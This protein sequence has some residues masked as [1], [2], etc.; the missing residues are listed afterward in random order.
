M[1][2]DTLPH[3]AQHDRLGRYVV[4]R[5]LGEGGMGSVYEAYDAELDRKVAVKVV[6]AD[7]ASEAHRHEN[8]QRL[9]RE[10]QAMARITHPN[11][12]AIHDVGTVGDSVFLAM[13]LVDGTTLRRWLKAKKRS[14][15]A[16][17][18]A[19]RQ[20]GAGLA[21]AHAAGLV[22]RDFK[23]DNVLV[24]RDGRVFVTDF[25]LARL[26]GALPP[27]PGGEPADDSGSSLASP[28]TV[29]G[30]VM[31]TP[32]YMS[33]EQHLGRATDARTDQFSFC[34]ALYEA[35]WN[36][37]PF[38]PRALAAAARRAEASGTQ[39]VSMGPGA[40]PERAGGRMV[41]REPPRKPRVPAR[42][43]RAVQR[44]LSLNPEERFPSLEALLKALAPPSRT[45]VWA[46]IGAGAVLA[47]VVVVV[48]AFESGARSR[49]EACTGARTAMAAVWNSSERARF[50]AAF[51]RTGAPEASTHFRRMASVLDS[52]TKSWVKTSHASCVETRVRGSQME[53]AYA[54]RRRCL[55]RELDAFRAFAGLLAKPNADL[56]TRAE[57]AAEELPGTGEC[58]DAASLLRRAPLPKDPKRA[59]AV[60]TADA[61]MARADASRIAGRYTEALGLA[62]R[63]M[64]D[65]KQTAHAPTEAEALYRVG[66]VS[67]ALGHVHEG[68]RALLDGLA[69]AD[70]GRADLLRA[71]IAIAL[72]HWSNQQGLFSQG[73]RWGT[74]ASAILR[75]IGG[76]R[77]LEASLANN[78]GTIYMDEGKRRQEIA[79]FEKAIAL[80]S[81]DLGPDDARVA[82]IEANLGLALVH[83]GKAERAREVSQSAVRNLVHLRGANSPSLVAAYTALTELDFNQAHYGPA[84]A[85][86]TKALAIAR[87]AYGN[88]SIKVA[89]AYDLLATVL[90]KKGRYTEARGNYER[91]LA[92]KQKLFKPGAA[93]LGYS[94]GDIGQCW[95][96]E[97]KPEKAVPLLKKALAI[98]FR[99]D[100][101]RGSD[102]FALATSLWALG[103]K[104][105]APRVAKQ[106]EASFRAAKV[107][108]RADEVTS[109]LR[110]KRPSAR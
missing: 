29:T 108:K 37:R 48:L 15:D 57:R 20:A 87:A 92:I 79:N 23:P 89:T 76:N 104:R 40:D 67:T 85:E 24:S 60:R 35:L 41:V 21:A 88:G 96:A 56:V 63:A 32:R 6:R 105:E 78:L 73:E 33:P 39:T 50:E 106:A 26:A 2:S 16:V 44:G 100:E 72:I 91:A 81:A 107:P 25:G 10:A 43:R 103:R 30:T 97:G 65:A 17:L 64:R 82:E 70:E 61:A 75:R 42:A 36:E 55:R 11:V 98:P 52:W 22:H 18:A 93:D 1:A 7:R 90:Q 59:E 5:L 4:L 109:W 110:S 49:A 99:D 62:T 3:F 94:Y 86:A 12:L 74:A 101:E 27:E 45:R 34:A 71:K 13:D 66:L 77:E 54:V 83:A 31:G 53:A 95:A 84:V 28:L 80:L 69:R 8:Q 102:Q 38:D 51:E 14:P 46:G 19:F 68:R 9:L 47:A 58:A